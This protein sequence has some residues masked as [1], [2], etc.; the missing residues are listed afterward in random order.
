MEGTPIPGEK[1]YYLRLNDMLMPVY[2]VDW[3]ANH[4]R[5]VASRIGTMDGVEGSLLSEDIS[6][7]GQKFHDPTLFAEVWCTKQEGDDM[8]FTR[9]KPEKK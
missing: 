6:D 3:A 2:E 7:R 4:W 8:S 9:D 1:K 5:L